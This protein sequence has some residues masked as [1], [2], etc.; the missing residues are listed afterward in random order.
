MGDVDECDAWPTDEDA[1]FAA[2]G[3]YNYMYD[4]DDTRTASAAATSGGQRAG[5]RTTASARTAALDARQPAGQVPALPLPRQRH[6]ARRAHHPG[7]PQPRRPRILAVRRR[8]RRPT[9]ARAPTTRG[10]QSGGA[11]ARSEDAPPA[12]SRASRAANCRRRGTRPSS[13]R[14]TRGCPR[15]RSSRRCSRRRTWPRCASWA[16]P[17][18]WT[19]R[20]AGCR[21]TSGVSQA[22]A[23]PRA[24][25]RPTAKA[26]SPLSRE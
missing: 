23:R 20:S 3:L 4:A 13:R 17:S 25:I 16:S 24:S 6:D 9:A 12:R 7:R 10:C 11:R 8:R 5:L 19:T 21:R 1:R 22:R 2:Q 18:R 15:A 14:C 26:R